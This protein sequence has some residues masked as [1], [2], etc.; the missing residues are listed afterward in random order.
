MYTC[1]HI[2]INWYYHCYARVQCNAMHSLPCDMLCTYTVITA[3]TSIVLN[4]TL[5]AFFRIGFYKI[6]FKYIKLPQ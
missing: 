6:Q 1:T 3:S 2:F 4:N 5:V